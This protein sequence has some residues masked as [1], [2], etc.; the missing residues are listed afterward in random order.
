M[1]STV[2][3]SLH[4]VDQQLQQQDRGWERFVIARAA[5]CNG[6]HDFSSP[7]FTDLASQV[8]VVYLHYWLQ[9]LVLITKGES[10]ITSGKQSLGAAR[11]I[12]LEALTSLRAARLKN[13]ELNFQEQFI[14]LRQQ[15]IGLVTGLLGDIPLL[16]RLRLSSTAS[17]SLPFLELG[18]Q[19]NLLRRSF[20]DLDASSMV[21][22]ETD[23]IVCCLLS[24][25]LDV[26]LDVPK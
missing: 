15:F 25:A 24:F 22:L 7:V 8:K 5:T 1:I 19:Y 21:L 23:Q 16:V 17:Y 2:L 10:L 12:F 9:S 14:S 11:A 13:L 18:K 4:H 3:P 26:F 20:L 6:F